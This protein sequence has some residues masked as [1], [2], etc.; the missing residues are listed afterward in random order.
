MIDHVLANAKT[1]D[2]LSYLTDKIGARLS[3]SPNAAL[4]VTWATEQFRAW[5]IDVR[6]E[7][8]MVP[9][10]VRGVERGQLVS[11]HDQKLVLTALGGSVAT[12][13]SGLTADVIEVGSYE[14]LEKLGREK[15]KGKIV[16]YNKAMDMSLVES[17]RAFEA[18]G[19]AVVFRGTG[20]SRAAEF[21]A[22]ASVIRSVASGSLR[23]PHTGSMRYAD[24]QSKIPAAALATEDAE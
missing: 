7:K 22:V 23:S 14:E 8:V 1:Y 10:W 11:H 4:A 2:H 17:G 15:I 18:Y 16:F 9:H 21:G 12:P 24:D 3:G 20:A 13:A 5:G 19:Q 6:Q